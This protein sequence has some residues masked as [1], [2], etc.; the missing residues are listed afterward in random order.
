MGKDLRMVTGAAVTLMIAL[1]SHASYRHQS[2]I[3]HLEAYSSMVDRHS[4]LRIPSQSFHAYHLVRV[5]L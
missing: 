2:L 4:R 5:L 3:T 1:V